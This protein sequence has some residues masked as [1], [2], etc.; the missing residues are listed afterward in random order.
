MNQFVVN[1][2]WSNLFDAIFGESYIKSTTFQTFNNFGCV[3]LTL[4]PTYPEDEGIYTCV[5]KNLR[6]TAQSAAELTTVHTTSLQLESKHE[7][8]LAQIG[9][10]EGQ[11]V[12]H[13]KESLFS[14]YF[15]AQN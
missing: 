2:I 7:H 14:L 13:L 1:Y 8:S 3:S 11:Q 12:Y 5:L 15:Q 10:L 4:N 9:Y 6:G